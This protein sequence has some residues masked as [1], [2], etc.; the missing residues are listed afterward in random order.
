MY[1]A[2]IRDYKIPHAINRL[3]LVHLSFIDSL[4]LAKGIIWLMDMR[5]ICDPRH[6]KEIN[7][8]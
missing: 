6:V 7:K 3:T 8:T 2:A 5:T 4:G 1:T